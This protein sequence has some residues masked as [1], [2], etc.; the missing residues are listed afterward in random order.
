MLFEIRNYH[1][2]PELLDAYREWASEHAVPFL[3][4]ELDVVGF[5]INSEDEPEVL[6][7]PHDELGTAN[8]TWVLRWNDLA[9]RNETMARVFASEAWVEIFSK[10]PGGLDSYLRRESKFAEAL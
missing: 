4:K 8:V 7:E 9:Q 10:V 6:G 3:K 1:F 5:W 2:R